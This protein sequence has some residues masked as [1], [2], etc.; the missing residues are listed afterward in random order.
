MFNIPSNLHTNS[1]NIK[2]GSNKKEK[3]DMSTTV[4]HTNLIQW[5]CRDHSGWISF[6]PANTTDESDE[7][8]NNILVNDWKKNGKGRGFLNENCTLVSQT[9]TAY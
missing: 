6:R 4:R 2:W 7:F 3:K 9:L 1:P 5:H 8:S